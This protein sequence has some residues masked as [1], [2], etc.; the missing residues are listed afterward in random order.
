MRIA[1]I[2]IIRVLLRAFLEHLISVVRNLTHTVLHSPS[3]EPSVVPVDGIDL[4]TSVQVKDMISGEDITV[5]SRSAEI[6]AKHRIIRPLI[7]TTFRKD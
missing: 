7:D 2:V 3:S 5:A 4:R 1:K 6:V